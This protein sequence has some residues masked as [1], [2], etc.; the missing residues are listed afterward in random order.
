MA[1]LPRSVDVDV[2]KPTILA[3]LGWRAIYTVIAWFFLVKAF[4]DDFW[5]ALMLFAGAVLV[6]YL[7]YNPQR[8][9]RRVV[10]GLGL[11]ASLVFAVLALLGLAG[12]INISARGP[13]HMIVVPL[14]MPLGGGSRFSI[15]VLWWMIGV[16]PVATILDWVVAQTLDERRAREF[17]YQVPLPPPLSGKKE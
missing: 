7:R 2:D 17:A 3:H 8:R 15:Q 10:R 6:D 16:V 11:A 9:A 4:N 5:V 1:P 13:F 12:L 14:S